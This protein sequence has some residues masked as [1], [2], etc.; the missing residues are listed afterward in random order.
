ME[1][2]LIKELDEM[3]EEEVKNERKEDT[4]ENNLVVS[5][6]NE[7][8]NITRS[9]TNVFTTIE[10][11]KKIFNLENTCDY[12]INDCK[13]QLIRVKD[14]LI[15]VIEKPMKEPLFDEET[16][17]LIKDKEYKKIC[18]LID[19][20]DKSYVTASKMFT[21]QMIRYISLFG[22]DEITKNGLEIKIIEKDVKNSSN[23]ALGFEL[24]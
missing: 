5:N 16:G 1:N 7:L 14:V 21:N 17:E 13:G 22:F 24:V 11:N 23:K 18:I 10:D 6:V 3:T 2:D 15:K 8:S 9:K 19:D 12:K 20:Q 4:M